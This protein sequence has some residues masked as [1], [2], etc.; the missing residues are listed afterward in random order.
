MGKQG[1]EAVS[2]QGLCG[3]RAYAKGG[4]RMAFLAGHRNICL[5]TTGSGEKDKIMKALKDIMY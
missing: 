1:F 2:H 3:Q 5:S 4:E